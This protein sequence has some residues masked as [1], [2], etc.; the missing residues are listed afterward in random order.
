MLYSQSWA[1]K[2]KLLYIAL[3]KYIHKEGKR[4]KWFRIQSEKLG[5]G[6]PTDLRHQKEENNKEISAL[7]NKTNKKVELAN[8]RTD[9]LVWGQLE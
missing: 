1:V 9:S 4:N 8:P 5:K 3:N 2:R 6:Q 7:E